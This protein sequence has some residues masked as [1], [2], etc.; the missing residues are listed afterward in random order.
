MAGGKPRSSIDA[1]KEVRELD[2]MGSLNK[3]VD[4]IM[5]WDVQVSKA[6]IGAHKRQEVD[7]GRAGVPEQPPALVNA[8]LFT[9]KGHME[10]VD[11]ATM[12]MRRTWPSFT[13]LGSRGLYA[14]M[15]LER[16][17]HDKNC[18]AG[19]SKAWLATFLRPGQ[20]IWNPPT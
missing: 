18:W 15:A 19:A 16:H 5:A 20:V 4:R 8:Q 14:Q 2:H 11:C 3:C 9:C 13:P 12:A 10:S 6:V 17:C 7:P 1:N